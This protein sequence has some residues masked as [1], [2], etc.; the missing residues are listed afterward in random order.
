MSEFQ[1]IWYEKKEGVAKITINRPEVR[2]AFRPRT[3]D[4]M[5]AAFYDAWHDD[6][7]GVAVLTGSG[8][9]AFCSGG[10]QKLRGH[11]GYEDENGNPRLQVLELHQIFLL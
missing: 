7:I 6:D 8:D 2:N 9:M 4:E 3:V 10:D 5:I 11:G 1:D